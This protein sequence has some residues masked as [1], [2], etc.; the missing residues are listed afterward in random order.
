MSLSR[1]FLVT[2]ATGF[3]GKSLVRTLQ[4]HKGTRVVALVR[5]PE[6][7]RG[8]FSR[9]VELIKGDITDKAKLPPFPADIDVVVHAAGMLG[10]FLVKEPVY[11]LVN[12]IGTENV[13]RACESAGIER[14]LLV[15]SAGVLGPIKEPPADESAPRAPSN[16][17]ERSKAEAEE[18]TERFHR[19]GRIRAT[20]VRPDFVYGPGDLHLLG[21]FRAIRDRRFFLIGTGASVLH[22]TYIEDVSN[23]IMLAIEYGNFTCSSFLIAGERYVTVRELYQIIASALDVPMRHVK[24]PKWAAY[25]TAGLLEV[26]GRLMGK[27]VPL[28]FSRVHF[29]TENRASKC[30][31]ARS[32]LKY[33]PTISVEE[34]VMETVRWYKTNGLL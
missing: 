21:F 1:K 24:L 26:A 6:T 15:S 9:D 8:H 29:L 12:A 22:P 20:I 3:L 7:A 2:G 17:Y 13:L 32:T 4:A 34:G 31:K 30:D 14:F 5:N 10:K 33:M 28:T 27:E 18:I 16:G 11:H 19:E 25:G 23:G